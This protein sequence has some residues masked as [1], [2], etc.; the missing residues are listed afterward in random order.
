M[1][2]CEML[3]AVAGLDEDA[4]AQRTRKLAEG[5]W[6]SFTAAERAAFAFARK[7]AK[8]PAAL[9]KADFDELVRHFGLER[10]I[11]VVYWSCRCHYMTRVADAFQ[12]PLERE[13]VF[14]GKAK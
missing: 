7:Q 14:R 1:G 12:L 2:H 10:A 5:D 9:G 11:D 8:T 4:I 6:S 13:N 3:L